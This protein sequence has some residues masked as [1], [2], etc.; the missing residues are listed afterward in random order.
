[1]PKSKSIQNIPQH[2]IRD[3]LNSIAKALINAH[4]KQPF[5]KYTIATK[6]SSN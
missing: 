1:M 6:C 4:H 3:C 2:K 5:S